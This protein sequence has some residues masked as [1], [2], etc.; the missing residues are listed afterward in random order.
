MQSLTPILIIAV[1]ALLVTAGVGLARHEIH[2]PRNGRRGVLGFVSAPGVAAFTRIE[3]PKVGLQP[4]YDAFE[5]R[6]GR[7]DAIRVIRSDKWAVFDTIK[8]RLDAYERKRHSESFKAMAALFKRVKNIAGSIR[9]DGTSLEDLRSRLIEPAELALVDAMIT[10]R[11]VFDKAASEQN[12]AQMVDLIADL[13]PVVDRFFQDVLVMADDEQLRNARLM[14]LAR[15]LR[16]VRQN[17]GDIS[18][19]AVEEGKQA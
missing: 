12:F 6:G 9:D 18:E 2:S 14:L 5:Q 11:S 16:I 7:S 15:L 10:Q 4:Q 17:I 8:Q 19:F 13:Q 3:P 1:A